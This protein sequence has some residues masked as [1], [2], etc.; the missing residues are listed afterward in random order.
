MSDRIVF[1][2]W[3]IDE[4]NKR[5]WSQADLARH[6]GMNRQVV[7]RIIKGDRIPSADSCNALA[8]AFNLSPETVFRKAG[9][10]PPSPEPDPKIDEAVHLL[11]LLEPDDLEE[12]IQITR[13]KLGKSKTTTSNK[14]SQKNLARTV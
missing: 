13:L 11:N 14:K 6:A 3:L 7:N 4:M 12:I 10:L 1:A 2:E 9:L 8:N 5:N